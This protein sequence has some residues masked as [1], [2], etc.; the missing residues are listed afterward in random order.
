MLSGSLRTKI[1]F[2]NEIVTEN[3]YGEETISYEDFTTTFAKVHSYTG[4]EKFMVDQEISQA[5]TEMW[6]RYRP[7]LSVKM[8]IKWENYYK[9]NLVETVYYKIESIA[10]YQNRNKELRILCSKIEE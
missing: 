3:E 6:V 4:T 2:Q 7:N 10:N 8:R 5:R 9:G 1:T